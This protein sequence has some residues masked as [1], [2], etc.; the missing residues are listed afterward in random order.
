MRD[1]K[2]DDVRMERVMN[3]VADSALALSDASI[4]TELGDDRGNSN[5]QT[6]GVRKI[7]Y[8]ACR[9]WGSMN[10]RLSSL[11]HMIDLSDWRYMGDDY[12]NRCVTCGSPV[13][14]SIGTGEIRGAASNTRCLGV[15]RYVKRGAA[16]AF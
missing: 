5:N 13:V 6:E 11:G 12:T 10:R 15:S 16:G 2:N 7:L 9:S 8:G 14:F 1:N 4:L 3:Q